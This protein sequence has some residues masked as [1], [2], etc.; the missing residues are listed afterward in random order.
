VGVMRRETRREGSRVKGDTRENLKNLNFHIFRRKKKKIRHET[1][2]T[3]SS[4]RAS[5]AKR[6]RH[7]KR[8][9]KASPETLGDNKRVREP[10]HVRNGR[11]R[12][13]R[14]GGKEKKLWSLESYQSKNST[15]TGVTMR[16]GFCVNGSLKDK[17]GN[18]NCQGGPS[19]L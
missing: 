4:R 1:C 12:E 9:R 14:D 7:E 3:G 13:V 8:H 6:S 5:R 18:P 17:R 11:N 15:G 10:R 2:G 19:H 16:G